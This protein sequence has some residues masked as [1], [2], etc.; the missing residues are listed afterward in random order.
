[1]VGGVDVGGLAG[2]VEPGVVVVPVVDED[3]AVVDVAPDGGVDAA[4]V[5][6]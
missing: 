4:V 1:V 5:H 2:A 3:V 6:A